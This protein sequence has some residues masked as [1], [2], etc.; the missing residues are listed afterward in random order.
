MKKDKNIKPKFFKRKYLV[1]FLF[2][3]I[4]AT[5]A[6]F[7]FKQK[8]KSVVSSASTSVSD[9][10]IPGWWLQQYFGASVC[11]EERCQASFDPDKD[12][13]SNEQ[14]FFYHSNPLNSDTNKNGLNDGEDVAN[15]YDPS[16]EGNVSFDELQ[17]DE[18][19]L[20]ESLIFDYDVK[21]LINDM[22]DPSKVKLPEVKNEEIILS[23]DNSKEAKTEYVKKSNEIAAKYFNFDVEKT[24]QSAAQTGDIDQI[25]EIKIRSLKMI[26]EFKTLPVPPD[27]IQL[28]K[29]YISQG[30][31]IPKV[32]T[33]PS[34]DT[35]GLENSNEDDIWYD[36]A[37]A[38]L[39][40]LQK[41]AIEKQRIKQQQ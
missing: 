4:L 37:Q 31:L 18:G 1:Y 29:Y 41:I 9:S 10:D 24:F 35:L 40:L 20:N 22:T 13:L 27:F 23:N 25:N 32:I 17:S 6:Y 28:H 8:N 36:N 14:E 34:A 12:K 26:S 19:I 39:I 3:F 30:L 33:I 7:G 38:Y 11:A 5:S 16:K 15:N 2:I 21:Q